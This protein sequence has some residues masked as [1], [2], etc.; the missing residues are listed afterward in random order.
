MFVPKLT[1]CGYWIA[2]S[3]RAMTALGFR[4]CNNHTR[5]GLV[6]AGVVGLCAL[7]GA[8]AQVAAQGAPPAPQA[9][10]PAAPAAPRAPAPAATPRQTIVIGYVDVEDDPRYEPVRAYERVI[11][12][13]REHP[14]TGAEVGIDEAA[15]LVRV[16]NTTFK[17][18]RITVK[19]AA[20]VAPAVL[21]AADERKISFFLI[22]APA[23]A[24]KPLAAAVAGHD[25]LLFNVAADDDSLRRNLCAREFVH[26]I[27]SLAMRMD[28]LMQYLVSRKWRDILVL[29]GPQP[30]DA[31]TVKAF[32]RSAQKFGARIVADQHFKPGTD[33]REREQNDPLLLTAIRSNYDVVFVAD[34][35]FD[36]VRQVPYHTSQPRP[37][38]GSIDLEPVAWHWTWERNGAPQVNSRFDKRSGGRHME[39]GDWAAWIAVKMIVQSTLRTRSNDFKKQRDFILGDNGFDGDKGLPVGVRPWDHQVRQAVLLA[40]PYMVVASAPV[41]GFLHRTNELDTLGDDEPETTCH[42][43]R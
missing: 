18:E 34:D 40:A 14:F 4:F 43:N 12:K 20:E 25:V 1:V 8:T 13:T 5:I 26:V 33:P 38:V 41:E 27:P 22:D 30:A 15:A 6:C 39:G 29:E 9:P 16:L 37:V 3:S 10:P 17:L 23:E 19:S 7:A 36:F 42:L 21:K 31:A 24:F 11:L 2:R 32:A 28:A 35:A